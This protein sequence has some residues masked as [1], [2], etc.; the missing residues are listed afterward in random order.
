MNRRQ[1]LAGAGAATL[2]SA[3]QGPGGPGSLATDIKFGMSTPAD[4]RTNGVHVWAQ[5]FAEV[6]SNAGEHIRIYPNSSIGGERE[7]VIQTQLG[8]LE[9]NATGGDELNH[10]SPTAFASARPFMVESYAHMDR[11]LTETP[12]LERISEE[13]AP[14]GLHV[15]AQVFTG[16]MVGLFTRGMP[17]RTVEELRP[18]RLRVLSNTDMELLR[19]WDVSGV[20][21]AWEEVAQALQTGMVDAYLNP[22]NVAVMFGHGSVLDYFT[23]LRMGPSTRMIVASTR[24]LD[25]LSPDQHS[26]LDRAVSAGREANR[27]WLRSAIAADRE[28]LT[29]IGI[30]WIDIDAEERATW[31]QASQAIGEGIRGNAEAEAQF[32][33]W[34]DQTRYPVRPEPAQ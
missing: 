11:L 1:L 5:A 13:I 6:M 12:I 31:R 14:H 9:V 24:W 32:Q 22:P 18:L 7:R 25:T 3:C 8:L 26:L 20:Q 2:L 16:P 4:A 33:A 30:E 19:A 29:D 15:L 34:V 23:D 28:R 21:V 17:V 10:W 27:R